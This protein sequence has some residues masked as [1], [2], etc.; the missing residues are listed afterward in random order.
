MIHDLASMYYVINN[1][2]LICYYVDV[3]DDLNMW[4]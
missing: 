1:G 2:K 4:A 3:V